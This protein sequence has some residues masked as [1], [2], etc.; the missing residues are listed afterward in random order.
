MIEVSWN[1]DVA[2]TVEQRISNCTKAI[3]HWNRKHHI[4]SQKTILQE[5]ENLEKAMCSTIQ[6][7]EVINSINQNL[8]NAYKK[9]EEYWRQRS[10][11]LW[12]ALGDKNSGYFHAISRGRRATNRFSILEDNDEKPVFE[13][14]EIV[15]VINDYFQDLFIT[16]SIRCLETVAQAIKP[17]ISTETNESL[18]AI[19]T[20]EE[21]REALFSI[22]PDKAPG[23]DGFSA[24]FFQTNWSVV[25][26]KI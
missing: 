4:N 22:H 23:P 12:L 1:A 10:R 3:S 15:Q 17:C 2:D 26:E 9:E 21:I 14:E 7:Q 16:R 20:T 11:T 24:S 5:K 13:E 6:D 25:K 19:P 8:K 18:I